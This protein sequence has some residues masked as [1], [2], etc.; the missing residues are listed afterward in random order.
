LFAD[1]EIFTRGPLARSVDQ[2]TSALATSV[3]LRVFWVIVGVVVL[4]VLAVAAYRLLRGQ[5]LVRPMLTGWLL[6]PDGQRVDEP[7]LGHPLLA[8]ALLAASAAAVWGITRL[9]S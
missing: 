6:L 7:R 3:H 9:G 8:L 1:D 2:A 5:D 4:H